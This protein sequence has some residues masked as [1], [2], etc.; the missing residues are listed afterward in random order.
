MILVIDNFDSFVFNLARY[1]ENTGHDTLVIRN[2]A[3]TIE[4][5]KQLNPSHIVISPGPCNPDK[6]GIS[7]EVI[8]AFYN[9]IPILGVCL[10]HQAI[11]QVFGAKVTFAKS[12]MHGKASIISHIKSQLFMGIPEAI[13]VGRYHSLIIDKVENDLDIIV[14]ATSLDNEVMAIE[15]KKYPVFGV[16]F[17]PES[18]LT[19]YGMQIIENF[20]HIRCN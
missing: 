15:H 9:T 10:G 6:S 8:T 5:I 7:L 20:V 16:Q 12:P 11:G 13:S 1:I 19:E 3:I 17:H 4:E 14:T 2:N 18:I